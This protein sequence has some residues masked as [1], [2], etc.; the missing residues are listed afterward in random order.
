MGNKLTTLC[1]GKDDISVKKLRKNSDAK[2]SP[3]N[4][5]PPSR[6]R[7][8][9]ETSK[10]PSL[11]I[12]PM[13][14]KNWH[15]DDELVTDERKAF[16][17]FEWDL[18]ELPPNLERLT[19]P[20]ILHLLHTLLFGGSFQMPIH[21]IL[22]NPPHA[23]VLDIGCGSGTWI[24]ENAVKYPLSEFHALDNLKTITKE[25]ESLPN[26]FFETR[27]IL[28]GLPYPDNHFDAVFQRFLVFGIPKVRWDDTITELIRVT[29]PGGYIQIVENS[30]ETERTGTNGKILSK[31]LARSS[32]LRG[33]DINIAYN[34]GERMKNLDLEIINE[35]FRSFPIGWKGKIGE[36][37]LKLIHMSLEMFKPLFLQTLDLTD[38]EFNCIAEQAIT[39]TSQHRTY[40]N[41]VSVVGRKKSIVIP[42]VNMSIDEKI[43]I[44]LEGRRDILATLPRKKKSEE[45]ARPTSS[46]VVNP[47]AAM[48]WH[49]D[50]ELIVD[51]RKKYHAIE[52]IDVVLPE[53]I[54]AMN[55]IEIIHLMHAHAFGRHFHMPIQEVLSIRGAKV[56]DVGCGLGSWIRDV[57]KDYPNADY[58]AL[59]TFKTISAEIEALPNVTFTIGNV[60]DGLPF[61]DNHF[62]AVFQR[63]LILGIPKEKWDDVIS[64]LKRVTKPGGYV[65]IVEVCMEPERMGIN[66]EILVKA[67][68]RAA[69]AQNVDPEIAFNLK[70]KMENQGL[71][72]KSE[73]IRSFPVAWNGKIGDLCLKIL[74]LSY[75]MLKSYVATPLELTCEEFEY[76][77]KQA[78]FEYKQKRSYYNSFAV[79]GRKELSTQAPNCKILESNTSSN[80]SADHEVTK[81]NS[82]ISLESSDDNKEDHKRHF[83]K[84]EDSPYLL[85]ADTEEQ[86][87]LESQHAV[88]SH[89]FGRLF[90]MP[91]DDILS[92]GGRVLDIGC[93]PG[94]WSRDIAISYPKTED[95]EKSL[96]DGIEQLPNI[97]FVEANVLEKIPYPD[98]YFDAVFQRSLI[99][100]IPKDKWDNVYKEIFRV[101]KPGGFV[102]QVE[103]SNFIR[104]GPVCT[105]YFQQMAN[106]MA[107]YGLDM[108]IE[109]IPDRMQRAGLYI[110]SENVVS[111][112]VG[113]GGRLGDIN[114]RNVVNFAISHK[115]FLTKSFGIT[116]EEYEKIIVDMESEYPAYKTFH[117][118]FAIVGRK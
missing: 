43:A 5:S 52:D 59:D 88:F 91:I 16:H 28:K 105:K 7:K 39:E 50:D 79:V 6:I 118:A 99:S 27:D 10:L 53:C 68:T 107:S 9:D 31:A 97:T 14:A 55:R 86:N 4:L 62:D 111:F 40:Y 58:Y 60:V 93:G 102:E 23:K 114:L 74:L 61:P 12:N 66:V 110:E 49:P 64:E 82:E 44:Y 67:L 108:E 63:S 33:I 81:K 48:K 46:L 83:H 116:G 37:G 85:P 94:T 32:S 57:R 22:A 113:W 115:S 117:N 100:S 13:A 30:M 1:T 38:D 65:E 56:L 45:F 80:L 19:R 54:D 106:A 20:E 24:Y 18:D 47:E 36:I 109:K 92:D 90:H 2:V 96:L 3:F 8:P 25:V 84:V 71:K 42:Y 35:Q 98:N 29:K 51:E 41:G 103:I 26:V 72:I 69:V 95:I 87:R 75:E 89:T 11:V 104:A 77:V 73:T 78:T 21:D 76:I 112:P 101:T 34:I 70:D 17:E 15:P